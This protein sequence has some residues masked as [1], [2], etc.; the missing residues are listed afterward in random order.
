MSPLA[1]QGKKYAQEDDIWALGIL[2]AELATL[3]QKP[4]YDGEDEFGEPLFTAE[5]VTAGEH[6][7]MVSNLSDDAR[8]LLDALLQTDEAKR[9]TIRDI[10]H[11]P[12]VIDEINKLT[13]SQEF[14]QQ[15]TSTVNHRS[16]DEYFERIAYK[17]VTF[18]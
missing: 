14:Q 7:S 2:F 18:T 13:K 11:F 9:P 15:F 5:Q 12:G 10:L 4:E 16:L 8:N 6:L 1:L 17:G 3:R